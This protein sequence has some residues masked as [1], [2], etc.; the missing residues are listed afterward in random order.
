MNSW[1]DVLA[2][3]GGTFWE[4]VSK[5]H[6]AG[7]EGLIG[8]LSPMVGAVMR[9]SVEDASKFIREAVSVS[10]IPSEPGMFQCTPLH[11]NIST[12]GFW[13]GSPQNAEVRKLARAMSFSTFRAARFSERSSMMTLCACHAMTLT[14]QANPVL[15]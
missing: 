6:A 1:A 7:L 2:E 10:T 15:T 4:E 9:S 5:F 8:E 12:H 13:R 3:R 14:S 11:W